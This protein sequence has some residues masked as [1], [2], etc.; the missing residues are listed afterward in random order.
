[1]A[2][3]PGR[4]VYNDYDAPL[5]I[6]SQ[7]YVNPVAPERALLEYNRHYLAIFVHDV[8]NNM[9]LRLWLSDD[10]AN[11]YDAVVILP[12]VMWEPRIPPTGEIWI[13]KATTGSGDDVY[14]TILSDQIIE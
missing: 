4:K 5:A 2:E 1:M 11:I 9:G 10:T 3:Y 12:G 13:D 8:G 7:A 14:I 6:G